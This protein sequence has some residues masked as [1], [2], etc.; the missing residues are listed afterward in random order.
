LPLESED[1]PIEGRISRPAMRKRM[2]YIRS[3]CK[4]SESAAGR[5]QKRY[6]LEKDVR[7]G[8]RGGD[9]SGEKP[10]ARPVTDFLYGEPRGFRASWNALYAREGSNKM[11]LVRAKRL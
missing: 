4:G 2:T 8:K 7:G 1:K 6:F 9:I 10:E 5:C 3:V 11:V